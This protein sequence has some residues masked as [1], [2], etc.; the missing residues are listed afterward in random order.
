LSHGRENYV[1]VSTFLE[2]AVL[3]NVFKFLNNKR[4]RIYNMSIL[5]SLPS[6]SETWTMKTKD[7]TKITA[8]K[9]ELMRWTT[10]YMR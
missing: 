5:T 2:T 3:N 7:I 4:M 10:K 8:A 1:K 6:G 9:M